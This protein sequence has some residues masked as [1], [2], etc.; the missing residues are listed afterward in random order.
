MMRVASSLIRVFTGPFDAATYFDL[1]PLF[2]G[3]P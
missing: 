3:L 2:C 1:H